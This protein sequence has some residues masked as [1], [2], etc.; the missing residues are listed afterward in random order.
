[1]KIISDYSVEELNEILAEMGEPK[2]RAK[3]IFSSVHN[4]KT[5]S[6]MTDLKISLRTQLSELYCDKPCEIIQE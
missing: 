4:G 1:M 2:F 3:Q 5:F 6:E